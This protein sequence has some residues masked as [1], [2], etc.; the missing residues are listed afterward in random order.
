MVLKDWKKGVDNKSGIRYY[1]NIKS[2]H[3]WITI[4]WDGVPEGPKSIR[5][6]GFKH[7][8]EIEG[9]GIGGERH[10]FKTKSKA[11]KVAKA[12]MRKH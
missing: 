4:D 7:I 12:Y 8:M 1:K 5:N 9:S 11:L 2:G 6:D 10:V 3:K